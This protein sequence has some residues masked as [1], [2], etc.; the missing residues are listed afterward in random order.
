MV[1]KVPTIDISL[2]NASAEAKADISR[3]LVSAAKDVGFFYIAG[4]SA[5]VFYLITVAVLSFAHHRAVCP[6]SSCM[7]TFGT[8]T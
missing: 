7:S 4:A 5:T 2:F 6:M 1:R 8:Q 3:Q